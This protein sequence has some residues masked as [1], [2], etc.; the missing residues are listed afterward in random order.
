MHIGEFK[1]VVDHIRQ[2]LV[3]GRLTRVN[4][5]AP[6][7][8]AMTFDPEVSEPVVIASVNPRCSTIFT[9]DSEPPFYESSKPQRMLNSSF[10]KALEHTCLGFTLT[11]AELLR[12]DDRIA[13]L[14]FHHTDQ[15]GE[16]KT[17]TLQ[18]EL[19]GRVAHMFLLTETGRVVSSMRRLHRPGTRE[20]KE[21]KR[22]IAAGKPLPPPPKPPKDHEETPSA[23]LEEVIM[24]EKD[25]FE[26]LQSELGSPLKAGEPEAANRQADALRQELALAYQA[27]SALSVLGPFSLAPSAVREI[28]RGVTSEKFVGRLDERG[29]LDEP[30]EFNQLISYLQRLAGSADKLEKLLAEAEQKPAQKPQRR[31]KP[32]AAAKADAVSDKLARFPYKVRRGY[33]TGG[34]DLILTFNAEG[35]LAA[36]KAFAS[37]HNYWFHARDFSGSYVLLLTGKRS[38]DPHDIEQAAVVAAAHSKGRGEARVEVCYTQ[39]KHLKKPKSAKTGTILRTKETVITVRP[40]AFEDMRGELFGAGD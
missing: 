18:I 22:R 6:G 37:A 32:V 19:T 5:P 38:P 12:P 16:E 13:L 23:P 30:I 31:S 15:Y 3:G 2:T 7:S 21:A 36:L 4:A 17:R 27:K 33:T 28:L 10:V 34:F 39:L 40:S 35:N 24:R 14:T 11:G 26:E 20:F 25:A 29:L 9:T 1:L 8:V